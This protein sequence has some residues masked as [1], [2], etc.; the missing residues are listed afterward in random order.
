MVPL[1]ASSVV[2]EASAPTK[3]DR[4]DRHVQIVDHACAPKGVRRA[5][6]AAVAHVEP[7]GSLGRFSEDILDRS[8]AEVKRCSATHGDRRARCRVREDVVRGAERRLVSPPAWLDAG[9]SP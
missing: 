8:D 6:P 4:D 1:S 3:E 9:P 7:V 2:P 5:V